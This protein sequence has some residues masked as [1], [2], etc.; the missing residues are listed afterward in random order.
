MPSFTNGSLFKSLKHKQNAFYIVIS[1]VLIAIISLG[2]YEGNKKSVTLVV[3]GETQE[4]KTY[5]HSVGKLLS[6]QEIEVSEFDIVT[7]SMNTTVEDGLSVQWEQAQEVAIEIDEESTPIWTTMN[8]VGDVLDEADITLTEHDIVSPALD[9]QIG[10]NKNI[11]IEKAYEF[12]LIDKGEKEKYWTTPTTIS[13]F[14]KKENIKIEEF[15][16]LEGNKEELVKP[17]SVVQIVRVEK[18][19]DVIEEEANFAVEKR[20][21]DNLLKGHEKVVQPGKKGKIAKE[22]EVVMEDGKEV[23][24]KMVE[25]KTLEESQKKIVAIGTKV[26]VASAAP[27]KSETTTKST[28]PTKTVVTAAKK[29]APAKTSAASNAKPAA[30]SAET[31]SVSRNNS[32]APEGGKEFYASA[33]AYTAYCNGCSGVTATG[34]N[35]KSNPNLKVIAVDPSVIPLGSKVWVEGY[36]YAVAGDT[37]GAIKGNKVDLHFPTKE[38]AYK[39]GRRQVKVKVIN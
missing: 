13:D 14:L 22:F 18:V 3:D 5:A 35:L 30:K 29:A 9:E 25:E 1:T 20:N 21:D 15:D 6:E 7:P 37:G 27:A 28:A 4:V 38:A 34:I 23:S 26:V 36:G 17:D 39:F 16:R 33:T 2:V 12:T 10:D 8:T 19:S 31:T 24:R 11:S 32:A